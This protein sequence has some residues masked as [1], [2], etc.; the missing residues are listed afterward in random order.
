MI[1]T[2]REEGIR[3]RFLPFLLFGGIME[4]KV[5]I[6]KDRYQKAQ[7]KILNLLNGSEIIDTARLEGYYI[8][9]RKDGEVHLFTFTDENSDPR[10]DGEVID[11]H[12]FFLRR[13]FDLHSLVKDK[14]FEK[15]EKE[16]KTISINIR[17]DE[18]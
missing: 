15:Q 10:L 16:S 1:P 11:V 9:F 14:I 3:C 2:R 8:L 17:C 6:G 12:P 4:L 13:M 7:E 5:K 18:E